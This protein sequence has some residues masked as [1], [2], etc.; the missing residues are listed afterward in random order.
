[1]CTGTVEP[2]P[3]PGEPFTCL[4][5]M[6]TDPGQTQNVAR[7]QQNVVKELQARWDGFRTARSGEV[8][9][10]QLQHDPAFR[11]LLQKSGYFNAV[12]PE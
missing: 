4:F 7:A 10:I 6:T 5:N 1:M 2:P 11:D 3:K 9:P 12:A 8:V